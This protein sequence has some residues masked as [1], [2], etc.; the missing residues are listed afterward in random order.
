M[1]MIGRIVQVLETGTAGESSYSTVAVLQDGA[2]ISYGRHQC[3]DRAGSLDAVVMLYLDLG[4]SMLGTDVLQALRDDESTRWDPDALTVS[5]RHIM[6]QLRTAGSDPIMRRAQD[7]VFDRHY[8]RPA[9]RQSIDMELVLP[10]SWLV[11]YDSTIQSG[12]RGVARIRPRFPALPPSRGGDEQTWTRQYVTARRRWL[13]SHPNREV[14]KSVY[15]MDIMQYLV[16]SD[17][18]Q[19]SPPIPLPRPFLGITL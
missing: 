6:E 19:L 7:R 15:R 4:G 8:W 2:G 12:T 13:A 3:T 9:H 14:Q 10:L 16:D 5:Q 11:V 18:W 1:D 17:N